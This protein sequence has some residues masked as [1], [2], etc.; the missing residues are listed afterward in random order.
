[1]RRLCYLLALAIFA[2]F[3]PAAASERAQLAIIIDDL[4]YGLAQGRR[5]INLPGPVACAILPVTPRAVELAT[6]AHDNGK[7]VL[8]HLPLQSVGAGGS[9]RDGIGM[10]T[11]RAQLTQV[12]A[13][14]LAAIP[15]VSGINNHMGSL[16]TRHPGHMQWL[17]A[18]IDLLPDLFFID[19]YTTKHSIAMETAQE[20][21]VPTA[22]RDV[23][24]DPD[25][26]PETVRRE[27]N[28]AVRL[29]RENGSAIAIGHPHPATLALLEEELPRLAG[30]GIDLVSL[31]SLIGQRRRDQA[32][33]IEVAHSGPLAGKHRTIAK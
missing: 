26:D 24:L 3:S 28:R 17:M 30:N 9:P 14:H 33:E 23:F 19:S 25:G 4:G 15:H 2:V 27:F 13:D 6:L 11:T 7:E 31:R 1:M 21:G 10:D 8:L 5:A 32:P 12:L 18:E 22:R 20:F 16:L 29:A